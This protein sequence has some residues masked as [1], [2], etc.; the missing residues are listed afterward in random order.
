MRHLS[1]IGS[2]FSFFPFEYK[3]YINAMTNQSTVK[4]ITHAQKVGI[5]INT[6]YARPNILKVLILDTL[7]FDYTSLPLTISFLKYPTGFLSF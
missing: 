4:N 6:G 3:E 7:Y 1:L 2:V 5:N